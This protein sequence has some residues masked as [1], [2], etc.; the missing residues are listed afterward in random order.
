MRVKEGADI[1]QIKTE[2]KENVDPM[3]WVCVGGS[4][5]IIVDHRGDEVILTRATT[6]PV[7]HEAFLAL[8]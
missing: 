1:E 7:L 4:K 8:E 3:K 2:I 5:N 6:R